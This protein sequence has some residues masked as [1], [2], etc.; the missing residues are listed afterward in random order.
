MTGRTPLLALVAALALLAACGGPPPEPPV[1][2][3]VFGIDGGDWDRAVPLLRQGKMPALARLIRTG[4]RRTLLTLPPDADGRERLSPTIWT[5]AATGVLPERHGILNFVTRAES[6]N[7]EPMTSNQRKTAALW[8]MLTV[9]N[10]SVGV[11]GWLVTWPAEPVKGYLVSSYTPFIFRW[12]AGAAARPIKGTLVDGVPDQVWP[13]ELQAEMEA[14]KVD[15]AAVP[16]SEVARRFTGRP[17]PPERSAELEESLEGMR[18]SWAADET[19]ERIFHHLA[20]NPPGGRRPDLEL[21]YFA[22]VDVISHRFWKYMEPSTWGTRDLAAEEVAAYGQ[23]VESAYRSVDETLGRVLAREEDPVR[24]IVLSDHGFRENTASTRATS[25]GWHRPEGMMIACGPGIRSGV[26]LAAGSVVDVA[27]TVLY[28]LGLPVGEDFDGDVAE[29]LFT[30]EY[31]ATHDVA[32]VPTWEDEVEPA[33][34]DA[35]VASPMD[36]EILERLKALGYLD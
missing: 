33:R 30:P 1:R 11:I 9:R 5:T 10:R 28:S 25:S 16:L 14:L 24:V 23:S 32:T 7:L 13:P 36:N 26:T 21:L 6:G 34:R 15:P 20:A 17:L 35:P 4:A 27:P 31:L 2:T 8:N 19:Y 12:G 3:I 29:G 22:G 18:W